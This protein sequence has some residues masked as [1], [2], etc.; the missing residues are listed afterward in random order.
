MVPNSMVTLVEA[1]LGGMIIPNRGVGD[2][3]QRLSIDRYL[4]VTGG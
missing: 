1:V 2:S 4:I 3:K